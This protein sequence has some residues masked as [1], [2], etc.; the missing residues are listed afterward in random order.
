MSLVT[1]PT[2]LK[3]RYI[4]CIITLN[5]STFTGS[6]S[7]NNTIVINDQVANPN[8]IPFTITA[9]INE[10]LSQQMDN[11]VDITIFGLNS[12]IINQISTI[13]LVAG[14]IINYQLN[15]IQ[16]YAGYDNPPPL[17]YT[18]QIIRAYADSNDPNRPLHLQSSFTLANVYKVTALNLQGN[19]DIASVFQNLASSIGYGFA[20]NGVTGKITNPVLI[21]SPLVQIR[22]LAIQTGIVP[23]FK[24][25]VL[26]IA[27]LGD[28]HFNQ[29]L[30]LDATSGMIG[31]PIIDDIGIQVR[32]YFNPFFSVGQYVNVQSYIKKANGQ[33]YSYSVNSDI[34]NNYDQWTSSVRLALNSLKVGVAPQ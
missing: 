9:N 25:N 31:Y 13:G 24:N 18:G 10:T 30:Q 20:N 22:Q 3:T 27:P 16:L 21:G 4:K 15:T 2:S 14:S 28:V 23:L 33:W 29:I 5:N 26:Y 8:M 19:I 34:S 7:G 1:N 32:M 12:D 11:S 6:G 17:I